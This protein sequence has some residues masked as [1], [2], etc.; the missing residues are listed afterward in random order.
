MF[1]LKIS[2]EC[3]LLS[4]FI[5]RF[6]SRDDEEMFYLFEGS[7]VYWPWCLLETYIG[8]VCVHEIIVFI[9]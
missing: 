7:S 6:K 1:S 2:W 5:R 9:T 8:M 4:L 3:S